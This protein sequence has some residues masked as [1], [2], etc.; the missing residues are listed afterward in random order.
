MQRAESGRVAGL[1]VVGSRAVE[2]GM[3][4]YPLLAPPEEDHEESL[5]GPGGTEL[6]FAYEREEG[7]EFVFSVA[8]LVAVHEESGAETGVEASLTLP[9]G[10]TI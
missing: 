6:E 2:V 10:T 4:A 5:A 9:L 1:A 7:R 8:A 3:V